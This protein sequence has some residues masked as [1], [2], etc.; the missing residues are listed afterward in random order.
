MDTRRVSKVAG[1][2]VGRP[3]DP[4][5]TWDTPRVRWWTAEVVLAACFAAVWFASG[6]WTLYVAI[7][8]SA[9]SATV[10]ERA[11]PYTSR[12]R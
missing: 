12:R 10:Q 4:P 11:F 2:P 5:A 9:W 6:D 3:P 8:L 1:R 7:A